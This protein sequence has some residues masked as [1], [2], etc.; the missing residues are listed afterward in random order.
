MTSVM[1]Y[2]FQG[3]GQFAHPDLRRYRIENS[4]TEYARFEFLKF[5]KELLISKMIQPSE[6]V[7]HP[8]SQ[9][10]ESMDARSQEVRHGNE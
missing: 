9:R 1:G 3:Q 8:M 4:G 2:G 7:A 5:A 6:E 10:P